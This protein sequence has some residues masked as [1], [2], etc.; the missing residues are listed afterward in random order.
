MIVVPDFWGVEEF[1]GAEAVVDFVAGYV[2]GAYEV[3]GGEGH[4]HEEFVED[5]IGEIQTPFDKFWWTE[6]DYRHICL[7]ARQEATDAVGKP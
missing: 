2:G 4:E 6:I 3:V 7:I 5:V 1:V